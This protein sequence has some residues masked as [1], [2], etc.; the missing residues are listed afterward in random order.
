MPYI[1][2]QPRSKRANR[3]LVL[4]LLVSAAA[5]CGFAWWIWSQRNVANQQ[6]REVAA[7]ATALENEG[8]FEQAAGSWGAFAA[9]TPNASYRIEAWQH[10]AA[11]YLTVGQYNNALSSYQSAATIGGWTYSEAAGAAAT[12][13]QMHNN[14]LAITYLQKAINLMPKAMVSRQAEIQSDE[15]QISQLRQSP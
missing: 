3:N 7:M 8:H 4:V 2:Q 1:E 5:I 15:Q 6:F 10:A 12:A 13:K 11:D 14:Q 9:H